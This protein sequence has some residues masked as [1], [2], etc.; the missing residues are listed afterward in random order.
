MVDIF[1]A[2]YQRFL[3]AIDHLDY[4]PSTDSRVKRFIDSGKYLPHRQY[5][6]LNSAESEFLDYILAEI[7][8][9][10][11][12]VYKELNREK[13]FNLMTWIVGWGTWSNSKN[14][15]KIKKNIRIL[16]TQNFLQEAQ[17]LELTHYMNLTMSQVREHRNALYDLDNR[18]LLVNKTLMTHLTM[19]E[20]TMAYHETVAI[21]A[22]IVL[23]RLTNGII[24]LRENVDKIYEYLRVMA[25]HQVNPM[26]LPPE[27]LRSVLKLIQTEMKQNPRLELPYHPD[28]DIWSYYSIM[29]VS[30][31]I[32]DDFLLIILTVPLMDKSLQMDLY[33]VHNLPA[34]HPEYKIQFTYILEGQYLALGKHKLYAAL[35]SENDIRI[36]LTT[37]GGL[38]MMN[39]ALYPV[40]K[41]DWCIY[42]LY[43][44]D[45]DRIAELCLVETKIRHA[46]LAVNLDGYM[47]AVS[48]LVGEKLQ[49]RCLTDT[50][51]E[52]ITP[53]LK[54]IYIGNGCEGYSS[55]ITIP[56]KSELTSQIDA[57]E[58]SA[59]FLSFND[60]YQNI[61]SYGIWYKLPK[62]ELTQEEIN[63]FGIHLSEFPPMILNHLNERI[64]SIDNKYPWSMPP[65]ILLAL[66]IITVIIW[67]VIIGFVLWKLYGMRSHFKDLKSFRNFIT[68]KASDPEVNDIRTQMI[69]LFNEHE[70]LRFLTVK[71]IEGPTISKVVVDPAPPT[72]PRPTTSTAGNPEQP[73][74]ESMQYAAT[75]LAKTGVDVK[76]FQSYLTKKARSSS[77]H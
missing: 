9:L 30:P 24:G 16:Q 38:C 25:G 10:R 73:S 27:S 32:M 14:I 8:R 18:L 15:K 45:P 60:K 33:K 4:H 75:A 49:I 58:R 19:Y 52:E 5:E 29:R 6:E 26:I 68:G 44:N 7:K 42:A 41:I 36:C 35:P 72:P 17:I 59:F 11:P 43:K 76:K 69:K 56:A 31:I 34:L 51:I 23:A 65:N 62:I 1:D 13:R 63:A 22:R 66:Q 21:E 55:S 57:P 37:N 71:P 46:N 3:A 2:V 74:S 28:I 50:Y 61:S 77:Q 48:S 40:E 39:H 64:K 54:I 20:Y 53:P 70:L 67:L 12:T 47:W